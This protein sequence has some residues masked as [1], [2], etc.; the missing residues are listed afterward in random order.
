ME[1]SFLI[2]EATGSYGV[3]MVSVLQTSIAARHAVNYGIA[4]ASVAVTF[5]W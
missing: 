1:L 5:A 4:L 2:R 3:P